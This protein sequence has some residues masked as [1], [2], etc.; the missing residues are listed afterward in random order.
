MPYA[1]TLYGNDPMEFVPLAVEA[2]TC[3]FDGIW[4]GE[5]VVAP[6][7]FTTPHPYQPNAD[8]PVITP[9]SHL[10]DIWVMVGLILGATSR[11]TVGTGVLQLPLR[12]PIHTARASITAWE[13][14]S[15]RLRMGVGLG[16]MVEEYEALDVPFTER[17]ARYTET[18]QILRGLWGGGAHGHDGRFFSFPPVQM[19]PDPVPIPLVLGG[20][21]DVAMQRVATTADGWFNPSTA[22]LGDCVAFRERIEAMRA[23]AGRAE[24][25]FTYHIRMQGG[26]DAVGRYHDAGFD[27]LVLNWKDLWSGHA[28]DVPLDEKLAG[29][30]DAADRLGLE[31]PHE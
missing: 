30:A 23:D 3:G 14:S 29:I 16:W 12:H 17:G 11:L 25:P 15:G 5:H 6:V 13:G 20:T 8:P 19:S 28:D 26:L 27:H 9:E 18:I 1:F 31:V 2:D 21:S 7:G 22:S 4:L 24:L 10:F